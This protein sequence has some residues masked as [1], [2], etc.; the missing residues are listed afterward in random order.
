MLRTEA[1]VVCVLCACECVRV[2][3]HATSRVALARRPQV[4]ALLRLATE[5]FTEHSVIWRADT[6]TLEVAVADLTRSM[7]D[8]PYLPWAAF[9]FSE[10]FEQ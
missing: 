2:D 4:K 10:L 7:W 9:T 3:V 8:A 5:G 1:C 6:R